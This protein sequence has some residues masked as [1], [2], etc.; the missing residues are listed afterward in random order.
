MNP[1]TF[2]NTQRRPHKHDEHVQD[3]TRRLT[4]H[5][6]QQT[7]NTVS[8]YS[9]HTTCEVM[10]QLSHEGLFVKRVFSKG[11]CLITDSFLK[12]QNKKKTKQPFKKKTKQED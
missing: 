7:L 9:N 4:G 11:E 5:I 6:L 12:K 8:L 3:E 2:V 10:T 1:P